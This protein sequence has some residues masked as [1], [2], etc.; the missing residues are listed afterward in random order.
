VDANDLH[1]LGDFQ[2]WIQSHSW[3]F[4]ESKALAKLYNSICSKPPILTDED[5]VEDIEKD[6]SNG[7]R[8]CT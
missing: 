4:V 2:Q 1:K 6:D 5:L 7:L 8:K 3:E